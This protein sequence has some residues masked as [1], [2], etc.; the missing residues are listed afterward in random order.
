M[1]EI[2]FEGTRMFHRLEVEVARNG[3]AS[4]TEML[5]ARG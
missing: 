2:L 1:L 5:P 4:A 3:W